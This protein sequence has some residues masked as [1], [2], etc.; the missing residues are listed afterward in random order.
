MNISYSRSIFGS[1][2]FVILTSVTYEKPFIVSCGSVL[3]SI[4]VTECVISMHL[5]ACII[6]HSYQCVSYVKDT[7]SELAC[8]FSLQVGHAETLVH[9]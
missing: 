5:C 6:M 2:E 7:T 4:A 9:S 1:V 8:K 3:I